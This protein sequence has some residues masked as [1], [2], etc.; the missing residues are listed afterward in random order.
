LSCVNNKIFYQYDEFVSH[1]Y[2]ISSSVNS[3]TLTKKYKK[4]PEAE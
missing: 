4:E 1:Y 2:G 3:R